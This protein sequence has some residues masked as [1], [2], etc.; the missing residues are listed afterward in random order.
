MAITGETEWP[1]YERRESALRR[2]VVI[3]FAGIALLLL[4]AG[5]AWYFLYARRSPVV[6]VERFIEADLAGD[7]VHQRQYVST[8]WDSR[9]ILSVLQ[10]YRKQAGASPFTKYQIVGSSE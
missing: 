4:A 9:F 8:R 6:V 7:N 10:T 1:V 5:I 3:L 2:E